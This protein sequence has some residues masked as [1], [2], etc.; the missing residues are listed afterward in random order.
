MLHSLV[1][2]RPD[3]TT[4]AV[5]PYMQVTDF[6]GRVVPSLNDLDAQSVDILTAFEVCEHLP[7]EDVEQIPRSTP[8]ECCATTAT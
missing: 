2:R 4:I 3:L 8:T 6:D 7:D 1:E 5:E